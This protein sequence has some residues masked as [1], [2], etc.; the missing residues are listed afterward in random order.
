[1]RYGSKVEDEL[2]SG[3]KSLCCNYEALLQMSVI[4][5]IIVMLVLR[6]N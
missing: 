4:D 6:L 2:K 3:L 5:N 1:M